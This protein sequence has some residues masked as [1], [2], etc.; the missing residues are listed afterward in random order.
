M[1]ASLACVVWDA[2]G[3]AGATVASC[4]AFFSS[5]AFA[6]LGYFF[7]HS[8]SSSGCWTMQSLSSWLPQRCILQCLSPRWCFVPRGSSLMFWVRAFL[9]ASAATEVMRAVSFCSSTHA[10][11]IVV[12]SVTPS[13]S[14][15]VRRGW[16]WLNVESHWSK[17][18]LSPS[19]YF[20]MRRG[21][22]IVTSLNLHNLEYALSKRVLYSGMSL[23]SSRQRLLKSLRALPKVPSSISL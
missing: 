17:P 20:L 6:L 3:D 10:A 23:H 18:G 13:T 14:P 2:G 7:L 5:Q 21:L 12:L 4:W 1:K 19:R 16:A 11:V 15:S 8:A 9:F 22:Q